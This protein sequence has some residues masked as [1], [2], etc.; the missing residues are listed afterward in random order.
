MKKS[1]VLISIILL[2]SFGGVLYSQKESDAFVPALR[3]IPKSMLVWL[4][5]EP[6]R[7]EF[8]MQESEPEDWS[9]AIQAAGRAAMQQNGNTVKFACGRSYHIARKLN[10]DGAAQIHFLGCASDFEAQGKPATITYS[11]ADKSVLSFDSSYGIRLKGLKLEYTNP[12][13]DGTFVSFRHSAHNPTADS[14]YFTIED[15]TLTGTAQ[16][17]KATLLAIDGA[18]IARIKTTHFFHASVGVRGMSVER[19]TYANVVTIEESSFNLVDEAI[20]DPSSNWDIATNAFEPNK[21]GEVVAVESHCEN[22]GTASGVTFRNNYIG[23]AVG[24]T[25]PIVKF[26]KASGL[27]IFGN[28]WIIEHSRSRAAITLENCE[29]VKIFGNRANGITNFVE[30]VGG[31]SHDVSIDANQTT[32][33]VIALQT[34]Q[35]AGLNI[36]Q[37][38]T[39]GKILSGVASNGETYHHDTDWGVSFGRISA[40]GKEN[41]FAEIGIL[42]GATGYLNRSLGYF[43]PSSNNNPHI[44]FTWD[45]S[46]WQNRLSIT[47]KI[48]SS[49]PLTVPSDRFGEQWKN[50]REVPTKADVYDALRAHL[51]EV[52]AL[53]E[54]QQTLEQK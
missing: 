2:L 29:G 14:A 20:V 6:F 24:Q 28:W 54:K 19:G 17:N 27:N 44:F 42:D 21:Q 48:T 50:S 31:T 35:I 32:A 53:I 34:A 37:P 30:A 52:S 7:P 9:D 8:Y 46:S 51:A 25:R 45:G 12:A 23:D 5:A 36:F 47:E 40:I 1:L 16:A 49:V 18:I 15:T 13:F 38:T 10:F 3:Y 43:A 26:K 39:H 22:C 41:A 11:G 4:L 33:Q